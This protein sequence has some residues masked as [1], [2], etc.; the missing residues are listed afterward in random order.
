MFK[1]NHI[2]IKKMV[3]I[4][5]VIALFAMLFS[6]FDMPMWT[7][8]LILFLIYIECLI[9]SLDGEFFNL[10]QIFLF[11]MFF[12]N[13]SIPFFHLFGLYQYPDGNL[14]LANTGIS[15]PI[16]NSSMIHTFVLE[17]IFL[18]GTSV[19]WLYWNTNK[20]IFLSIQHR[21]EEVFQSKDIVFYKIFKI[22]FGMVW[23]F[24]VIFQINQAILA[25]K[26]GYVEVI[27]MKSITN[28]W[29]SY[30]SYVDNIYQFVGLG[31]L[32]FCRNPEEFKRKS[33]TFAIPYVILLLTGQ[34]GTC[35]SIILTLI[36]MYSFM[37]KKIKFQRIFFIGIIV[38]F[39]IIGIGNYR[40]SRD[41]SDL[42]GT[43]Q[44]IVESVVN[45]FILN[46]ESLMVVPYTIELSDLFTNKVPFL[47]GYIFAIFS[48]A[49]NYSIEGILSKNYLAQH[50]TYLLNP[51]KLLRGSTIGTCILAEFYELTNGNYVIVFVLSVVLFYVAGVLL[52]RINKNVFMYYL[53]F[54]YIQQLLMSPR[55]SVMKIFNKLTLVYAL[56]FLVMSLV[57]SSTY[58]KNEDR[59]KKN[60]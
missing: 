18:L 8:E 46:S 59:S 9:V 60:V 21:N 34:R 35:I 33:I 17:E 26:F 40:W 15:R 14:V 32:F 43:G 47:F 56:I 45:E 22:I 12:F 51:A 48:F 39:I 30:L 36:F 54:S 57:S 5:I 10:Y 28:G 42:F 29:I 38:L 41:I 6:M 11:M 20:H 13:L 7:A 16:S 1:N 4:Q 23:P 53:C 24:E 44:H 2:Y 27:H 50:I 52:K 58:K 3:L 25:I 55:G 31:V 49:S 37:Y 19:G